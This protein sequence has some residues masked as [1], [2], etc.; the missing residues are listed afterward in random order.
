MAFLGTLIVNGTIN[1]DIIIL[2]LKHV[3]NPVYS[4]DASKD[5]TSS[6][7]ADFSECFLSAFYQA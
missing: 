2:L 3:I 4:S 1:G 6:I 7:I 5:I